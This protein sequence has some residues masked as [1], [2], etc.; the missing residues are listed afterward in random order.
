MKK[1]LLLFAAIILININSFSINF[2]GTYKIGT[3][4]ANYQAIAY[5]VLALKNGIITGDCIF[6]IQADY[7]MN[8][9]AIPLTIPYFANNPNNYKITFRPATNVS[10]LIVE[11]SSSLNGAGGGII[12]FDGAKNILF[13]GRAGGTGSSIVWT[14]RNNSTGPTIMLYNDASYIDLDYLQIQGKSNSLTS[15]LI[16]M[17]N[18]KTAGN[19]FIN[20]QYSNITNASGGYPL[21]ILYSN[22]TT[23]GIT[24]SDIKI[25]NNNISNFGIGNTSTTRGAI[26]VT[27]TGNGSN[28]TI[29]NNSFYNQNNTTLGY[30]VYFAAGSNSASNS[31]S[32]NYIGGQAPQCQG[33][34]WS[35]QFLYGIY[36]NCGGNKN[37][38]TAIN[39]NYFQNMSILNTSITTSDTYNLYC[40]NIISG[41]CDVNNNIIGHPSNSNG[42]II[43]MKSKNGILNTS[44]INSTSPN[45]MNFTN[46]FIGNISLTGTY[47]YGGNGIV[48][49][50]GTNNVSKQYYNKYYT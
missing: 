28:W 23:N 41:Y 26:T 33:T 49:T 25:Q 20:L 34:A 1:Q 45:E 7:D 8:N 2:S 43:N 14:I 35:S 22:N 13:D 18:G 10:S 27:G 31:I 30:A 44:F 50:T 12:N 15:G 36:V 6:E 11:G 46:N 29:D 42:I 48:A 37:M 4:G 32:G 19:K 17:G 9:E 40:I 21:N 3:T 16:V 39:N 24:N 38:K 47:Y 5:A